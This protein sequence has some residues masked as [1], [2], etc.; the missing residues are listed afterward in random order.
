MGAVYLA[1]HV[2]LDRQVALKLLSPRLAAEQPDAV[3]RFRREAR[4]AAGL[5][6]PH[7]VTVFAVGSVGS[8]HY[9][10]MEYVSGES[11]QDTLARQG[12]LPMGEA[13]R[14]AAQAARALDAAHAR[15]I[16]HRDIKPGNIMLTREG[17]V[18]VMDFGLAKEVQAPT[19]LTL[20]GT[21]MGTPYYMSPEQCEGRA[22]D[23]RS[24][25]YSLGATLFH[26]LAGQAPYTGDSVFAVMRQHT[27]LPVPDIRSTRPETPEAVQ[28]IIARA[29]AKKAEDRFGTAAEMAEALEAVL[30]TLSDGGGVSR[31]ARAGEMPLAEAR[32]WRTSAR[33]DAGA[34]DSETRPGT[35]RWKASVAGAVVAVAAGLFVAF[36]WGFGRGPQAPRPSPAAAAPPVATAASPAD[37]QVLFAYDFESAP[38]GEKPTWMALSG[39]G[40]TAE[41]T[42]DQAAPGGRRCLRVVDVANKSF[43]W[44]PNALLYLK[45]K[46]AAF[47]VNLDL[48]LE[49]GASLAVKWFDE[50]APKDEKFDSPN[51]VLEDGHIAVSEGGVYPDFPRRT[52]AALPRG[53]WLH[54]GMEGVVGSHP[55]GR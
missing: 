9:I 17:L 31:S 45:H 7:V 4:A 22:P 49:E 46:R 50:F 30:P 6:H 40:D 3:A 27:D 41:V 25:I 28:A 54:V 10:E 19:H 51:L 16:V 20:S 36:L 39:Q 38:V 1:R 14:F 34:D 35:G 37:A 21:I 29:M 26:L 52:L 47:R 43:P 8:T 12:R 55:T 5:S 44:R 32:T 33:Q 48:R 18:K 24:D 53:Q 2:D 42:E 23:G 15:G 11:L 13:V